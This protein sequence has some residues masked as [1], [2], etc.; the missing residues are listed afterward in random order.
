MKSDAGD[1]ACLGGV[2]AFSEPLHV[3]RPNIGDRQRLFE[4]INHLLDNGRLSNHG[5]YVVEVGSPGTELE[6]AL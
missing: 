6:F 5:T 4:R 3:G 2:P 1:L